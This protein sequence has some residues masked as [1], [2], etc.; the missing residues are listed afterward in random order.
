MGAVA[1]TSKKLKKGM[2]VLP[3]PKKIQKHFSTMT[4]TEGK[5]AFNDLVVT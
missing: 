3:K 4:A 2:P 5:S 1:L